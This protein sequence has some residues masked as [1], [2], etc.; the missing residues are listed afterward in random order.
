MQFYG[1]CIADD[2]LM[3][4]LEYMDGKLSPPPPGHSMQFCAQENK[5]ADKKS[6]RDSFEQFFAPRLSLFA[7]QTYCCFQRALSFRLH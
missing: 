6:V 7:S 1:A 4:V 2:N 5:I 3:L